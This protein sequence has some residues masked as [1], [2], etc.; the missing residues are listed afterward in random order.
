M[1]LDIYTFELPMRVMPKARPIVTRNGTYM[2]PKYV[3]NQ[4]LIIESLVEQWRD[5][6][7]LEFWHLTIVWKDKQGRGDGD[8]REGAVMDSLVKA[9]VVI[10]D[11]EKANPSCNRDVDLSSPVTLLLLVNMGIVSNASFVL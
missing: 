10:R 3:A 7:P 8:N 5:N 9:G 1:G 11:T 2:P 4:N 6:G